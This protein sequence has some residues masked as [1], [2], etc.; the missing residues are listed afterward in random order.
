M[1]LAMSTHW[2]WAESGIKNPTGI[3]VQFLDVGLLLR[4]NWPHHGLFFVQFTSSLS[5]GSNLGLYATNDFSQFS[6]TQAFS[7]ACLSNISS[8]QRCASVRFLS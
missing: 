4:D 2:G 3:L 5:I 1:D 6:E 7:C 8:V